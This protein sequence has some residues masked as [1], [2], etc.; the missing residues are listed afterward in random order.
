MASVAMWQVIWE[1]AGYRVV[2][3]VDGLYVV[4]TAQGPLVSYRGRDGLKQAYDTA[5]LLAR[6]EAAYA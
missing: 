5:R 1:F 3:R 2:A 4:W 6:G